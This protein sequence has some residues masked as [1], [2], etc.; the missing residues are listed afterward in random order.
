MKIDVKKTSTKRL[1]WYLYQ[2]QIEDISERCEDG[3]S[4]GEVIRRIIDFGIKH[5][6][7]RN[8]YSKSKQNKSRNLV[9]IPMNVT[10]NQF[11]WLEKEFPS[12]KKS[13][14]LRFVIDKYMKRG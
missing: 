12:R 1:N 8:Y 3:K 5:E 11:I 4:F 7:H 9:K 6:V 2:D 10:I 14:G 13:D